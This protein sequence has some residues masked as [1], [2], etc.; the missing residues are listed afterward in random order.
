MYALYLK[1]IR[2]F[3]SS[4]VGY[5]FLLIFLIACW[6]FNW[7]LDSSMNLINYGQADLTPFFNAAPYVFLILIPAITM[8]S[9]AEER[10]TGTIELLYTR[11]LSDLSILL[12]KYLAS[13]T[14]LLLAI[15]PTI[16][17][18]ITLYYL[19]SPSGNIDSGAALTSYLG[20]VLL[21]AAFVAIGIFS[22]SITTSQIVSFIIAIALCYF[23]YDGLSLLGNYAEFGNLDFY[24][25]Y[26]S[27]NFHYDAIKK[28][29]VDASDIV[30]NVSFI[31]LFL[32]ASLYIVKTL[33]K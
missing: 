5:V 9:L 7:M 3:L 23:F 20:L 30:F 18:Y 25:Q 13:L 27:L 12:A 8:K 10:R 2:G 16:V 6:L 24:L 15:M 4:V 11:P 32:S 26:V 21:G 29:V 1:E 17:Y 31:I 19:G 33:K 14:L 22:S 28:G